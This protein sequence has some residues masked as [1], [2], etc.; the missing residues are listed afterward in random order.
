MPQ[1]SGNEPILWLNRNYAWDLIE[2]FFSSFNIHNIPRMENQQA[3]SSAKA[4]ATFM[5]P[6]ILKL[7]YHIEMRQKLSIPNNVKHWQI[8]EDDEQI[9]IFLEMV[10][11]FSETHIDQENQNDP[12]WIMQEGEE[13]KKFQGKIKNH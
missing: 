3:D 9:K 2:N 7:N 13:P 11:E 10:D 4:V 1:L 6:T 5:P 8:F 12:I